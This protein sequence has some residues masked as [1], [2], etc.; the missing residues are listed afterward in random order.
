[1]F[2]TNP[3]AKK[4][5]SGTGFRVH[6]I[7]TTIQGEGPW[8]GLK[9][10]F[11]RLA[12]CN[13]RCSFCDSEFDNNAKDMTLLQLAEHLNSI[14]VET[15]CNRFVITGG[16][17]MLQPIFELAQ[18]MPGAFFQIETAGTVWPDENWSPLPKNM[19][20]VC[21]PKTPEVHQLVK[22]YCNDWKYIIREGETS[23]DDGLP[24]VSTQINSNGKYSLI[25]RPDRIMNPQIWVQPCDEQDTEATKANTRHAVEL[26]LKYGYRLSIQVHKIVGVD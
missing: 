8:V 4:R 6:S 3:I 18:W 13:L 11:V 21:S 9:S 23:K 10:I 16:E 25:Y 12:G 5:E 26:V 14:W 1:M 19:I 20:L 15:D 7:F 2:G 24:I 22:L 17:P